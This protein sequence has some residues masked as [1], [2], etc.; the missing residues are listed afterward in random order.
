MRRTQLYLD[1]EIAK[2]LSTVSRQTGRTIS[3][4]VRDCVR[5][6]FGPRDTV[7]KAALAS[8]IAGVWSTRTDLGPTARHVRNLR[9][10]TRLKKLFRA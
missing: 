5:E 8:E 2:V 6:K 3:S 7:D 9:K 10:G 4:L 1:E